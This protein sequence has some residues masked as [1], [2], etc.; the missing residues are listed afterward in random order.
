LAAGG[1]ALYV[2]AGWRFGAGWRLHASAFRFRFGGGRE[3]FLLS[4]SS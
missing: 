3:G 2:S 4:R 1:L